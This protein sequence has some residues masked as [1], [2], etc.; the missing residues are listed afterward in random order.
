M[1]STV[2]LVDDDREVR[3][4]L[5]QTLELADLEPILAGS[6]IEAKDHITKTFAGVIVTDLR[7][8]G[9]DGFH[10]L[11]HARGVDAELP[12]I[13]LTGEADVPMAVKAM[14]EGAHAFLEKPCAPQDLLAAI[15]QA[16]GQRS[17]VLEARRRKLQ[18][19]SGDAAARMLHGVSPQSDALR[20]RVRAVAKTTAEVL[21]TGEAGVG[22]PK[23]AEIIHLLSPVARHPFVKRASG[24]L[25]VDGLRSA[26]DQA[27]AGSLFL[28]EVG[29]LPSA[30]Q[31][32]LLDALEVGG[33]AR[34]IAATTTPLEDAVAAGRFS[35]D[36]FYRLD[37]MR[38][39]IPALRERPSDIPVL[40]EQYL[41]QACEQAALPVPP[42]SPDTIA[43]LMS[44]DWPG[45][46]RALMSAAMR[47]ALGVAEPHAGTELGLTEQLAQVE[48]SLLMS[49]LQKY[50]GR[51]GETAAALKLPRKTFYDK[52]ARHGIKAE[53]YRNA[54][55]PIDP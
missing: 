18:L 6:F 2:L 53:D 25:D 13:L 55:L 49:A 26:L 1:T 3:E 21:V 35:A 14:A 10:L 50:Q 52:L 5:G 32:A 15:E 41:A 17:E 20:T 27:K 40:F 34:V 54:K 11:E 23:V 46:A 24:S 37:L 47:Y 22:T 30:T 31:F 48:K 29:T 12:V 9:R 51:A 36:L 33:T 43:N 8:P 19:E 7:M 16:L 39:R 42:V 44:Q 28:D 4:A 38:V 45:N